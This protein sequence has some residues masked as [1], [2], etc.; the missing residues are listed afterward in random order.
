MGHGTATSSG[1]R[2][3][4]SFDMK[5]PSGRG[6][7]RRGSGTI[8][9]SGTSIGGGGS[10]S[11]VEEEKGTA[12]AGLQRTSGSAGSAG[13]GFRHKLEHAITVRMQEQLQF[14]RCERKRERLVTQICI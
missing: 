5:F 11:K 6:E 14:H 12:A 13:E 7:I 1:A 2:S 10:N 4:P 3:G 9:G 8:H